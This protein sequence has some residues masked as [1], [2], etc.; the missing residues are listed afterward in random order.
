M[1][2]TPVHVHTTA[3][4]SVVVKPCGADSVVELQQVLVHAVR[5][6]RPLRLIVDLDDTATVDPISLG[7]LAAACELADDHRVAL[8]VDYSC[9]AVAAQLLAAGVARQRLRQV[10]PRKPMT[11]P[12]MNTATRATA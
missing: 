6:L 1:P 8:F 2:D 3:D 5:K 4:G 11:Q 9:A 10:T 7:S 12:A